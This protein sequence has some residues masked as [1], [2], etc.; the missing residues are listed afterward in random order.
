M[1]NVFSFYPVFPVPLDL[2]SEVNLDVTHSVGL[3]LDNEMEDV[4]PDVLFLPSRLRQF[5]K[6]RVQIYIVVL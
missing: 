2:C 4:A 5:C 3:R 1:C 6:V